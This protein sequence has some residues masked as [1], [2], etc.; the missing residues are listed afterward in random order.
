MIKGDNSIDFFPERL[1]KKVPSLANETKCKGVCMSQEGATSM[2]LIFFLD[3]SLSK[4]WDKGNT[5]SYFPPSKPLFFIKGNRAKCSKQ[6]K[7]NY[8]KTIQV[9]KLLK[10]S[11]SQNSEVLD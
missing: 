1:M 4:A 10:Y 9:C 11:F 5:Y 3:L 8:Q 6:F 2:S 7:Q